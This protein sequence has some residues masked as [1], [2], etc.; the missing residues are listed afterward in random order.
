MRALLE[1]VLLFNLKLLLPT[2]IQF[3]FKNY[4][5]VGKDYLLLSK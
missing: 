5:L 4:L 2:T 3:L 1:N